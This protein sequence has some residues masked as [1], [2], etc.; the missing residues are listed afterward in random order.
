MYLLSQSPN[1]PT[2]RPNGAENRILAKWANRMRRFD[3]MYRSSHFKV[4]KNA[5]LINHYL[6]SE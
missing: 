5:M 1:S 3:I 6:A 2:Q 4:Q